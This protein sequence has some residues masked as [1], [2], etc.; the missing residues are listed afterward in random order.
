MSTQIFRCLLPS[1]NE[2]DRK[3]AV[4]DAK[5]SAHNLMRTHRAGTSAPIVSVRSGPSA[6][7]SDFNMETICEEMGTSG[8]LGFAL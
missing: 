6:Q 3:E 5:E 8:R 4:S 2:A 1:I 7:F